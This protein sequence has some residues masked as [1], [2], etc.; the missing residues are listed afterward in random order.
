M[1]VSADGG[2]IV[3]YMSYYIGEGEQMTSKTNLFVLF[4]I[5]D[6]GKFINPRPIGN[7]A[8]DTELIEYLKGKS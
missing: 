8:D 5:A 4:D 3:N 2:V 7:F 1:S 6:D